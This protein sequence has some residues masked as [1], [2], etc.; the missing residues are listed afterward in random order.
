ML[1][2]GHRD[3]L[4]RASIGE[5]EDRSIWMIFIYIYTERKMIINIDFEKATSR[6][7]R[8]EPGGGQRGED[9]LPCLARPGDALEDSDRRLAIVTL[10]V[11]P[12]DEI[13]RA[14]VFGVMFRGL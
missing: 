10:E 12:R 1:T 8:P 9:F 5:W 4:R 7:R 6:G 13:S 11:H 14:P 2:Q 3:L